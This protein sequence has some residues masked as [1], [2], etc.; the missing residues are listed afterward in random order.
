M[1][2]RCEHRVIAARD[3]RTVGLQQLEKPLVAE[4][5]HLDRLAERCPPLAL[6]ERPQEPHVDDHRSRLV[7]GTDQVLALGQ[8]HAGLA[9]DR[10]ST[11][12]TM[13]VGT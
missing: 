3:R 5:R 8:V 4:R 2:P 10:R 6:G 1:T 13:V 12:A 7:E 11:C 9:A